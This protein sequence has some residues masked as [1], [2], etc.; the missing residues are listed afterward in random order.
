MFTLT[1]GRTLSPPASVGDAD[2]V[3]R[4]NR[5]C[6]VEPT[7]WTVSA[8]SMGE[9][10]DHGL[11]VFSFCNNRPVI[12]YPAPTSRRRRARS[13]ESQFASADA[14][15]ATRAAR[16]ESRA[17]AEA[18]EPPRSGPTNA[19]VFDDNDQLISVPIHDNDEW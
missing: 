11:A 17:S 15:P 1:D 19:F 4:M 8:Q 13:T 3:V 2:E 14:S 10:Y 5:S 7:R 12:D 6:G 16:T 9:R 18:S